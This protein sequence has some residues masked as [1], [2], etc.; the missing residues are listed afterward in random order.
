MK[1]VI[2]NKNQ[3]IFK[4]KANFFKY[5]VKNFGVRIFILE[6]SFGTGNEINNYLLGIES[7]PKELV[8]KFRQSIWKT[9]EFL[10]LII[11]AKS[12]NEKQKEYVDKI[13]FYGIDTMFNYNLVHQLIKIFR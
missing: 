13:K 8:G 11:W 3:N 2:T 12:Y 5:L 9:N 6:E 1:S 7:N 4:I 10:D